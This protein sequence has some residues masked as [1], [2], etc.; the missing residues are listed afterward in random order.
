MT[1]LYFN[2]IRFEDKGNKIKLRFLKIFYT[3]IDRDLL[4]KISKFKLNGNEIIFKDVSE[5]KVQRR[6]SQLLEKSFLN[7]KNSV[8]R[9]K[10]VYIHKNSEIPLI[11]SV[12][13][14]IIERGTNI[15]ELRPI[16][17]CN[18]NC[19]Y[20][21]VDEGPSS[22]KRIDF[23][24]E[25]DYMV[26]ELKKLIKYK[27]KERYIDNFDIHINSQGEPLLYADIVDLVKDIKAIK[28]VKTISIDTNGTLLTKG[29][30]DKLAKAGLTRFNLSLNSMDEK[31]AKKIANSPYNLK[32]VKDIAGYITKKTDLIIAPVWVAGINDKDMPK[33]IEFSKKIKAGKSCPPIG[34]QSFLRYRYGRN[35][36]KEMRME[37]FFKKLEVLEK[38]HDIKLTV[39]EG[40][41]LI[42]TKELRKPFK[43]K[44]IIDAE[45]ILPG[46]LKNE[47]LAKAKERIISIPKCFK[48]G[49]VK[50]KLTRT[51]H[52]I[53]FGEAI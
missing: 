41:D 20:C 39:K 34:I 40:F 43:K 50:V 47:R 27:L 45:I 13:F 8:T 7:L 6:F 32:K 18:L 5:K 37:E 28:E 44:E 35:P 26:Y 9:R 36:A 31:T 42:K 11:G 38:K 52:N 30:I 22:R 17:G 29:L 1:K 14:G 4:E 16:T 51:K 33:L 10:T 49:S 21:S 46:R 15:I 48:E 3:Y 23:V 19:I 2:D 25:K 12:Y 53:F 24:V